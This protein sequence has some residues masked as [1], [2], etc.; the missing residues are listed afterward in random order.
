[1]AKIQFKSV[2]D[3]TEKI[4]AIKNIRAITELGLKDSLQ[5]YD[6]I[7]AGMNPIVI[8][9][10]RRIENARKLLDQYGFLYTVVHAD[11]DPDDFLSMLNEFPEHMTVADVIDSVRTTMQLFAK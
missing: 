5:T 6:Q 7:S 10:D 11:I 1:M 4:H 9:P 8:I 3:G 2:P